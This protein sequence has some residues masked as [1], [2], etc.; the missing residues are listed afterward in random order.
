MAGGPVEEAVQTASAVSF[1]Q[2]SRVSD[3]PR[4]CCSE[5]MLLS[6]RLLPARSA[7]C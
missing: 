6:V 5:T 2:G 4:L 7:L 3:T 1:Q